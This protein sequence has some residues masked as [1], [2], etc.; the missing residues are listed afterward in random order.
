M[1]LP[2]DYHEN[3]LAVY[4]DLRNI[5]R[6]VMKWLKWRLFNWW[7]PNLTGM[8]LLTSP[9]TQWVASLTTE[10][11]SR[12]SSWLRWSSN[13]QVIWCAQVMKQILTFVVST[14]G[15]RHPWGPNFLRC[16]KNE[17][18]ALIALQLFKILTNLYCEGLLHWT[19]EEDPHPEEVSPHPHQEEGSWEDQPQVHRHQLQVRPRKVPD[20]PGQ[21]RLHGSPQ[22]GPQ[23]VGRPKLYKMGS[24]INYII[25]GWS[26]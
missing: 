10:R 1:E 5:V 14:Y 13:T 20:P 26:S 18:A 6:T 2:F 17:S 19:Q 3:T 11:S 15:A 21:G 7:S 25:G 22:E 16:L 23:G 9:S 24:S 4:S 12:T 8:T